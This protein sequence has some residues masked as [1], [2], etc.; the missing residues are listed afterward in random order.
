MQVV[1][2]PLGICDSTKAGVTAVLMGLRKSKVLGVCDCIVEGD[3]MVAVNWGSSSI[4]GSWHLAYLLNEIRDL[5]K[6]LSIYLS[7]VPKKRNDVADFLAKR[8][9]GFPVI[10]KRNSMPKS[11]VLLGVSPLVLLSVL[12]CF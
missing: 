8:V 3:S 6:L 4:L 10:F 7:H 9:A 2:G 5:V 11:A 1:C 12:L